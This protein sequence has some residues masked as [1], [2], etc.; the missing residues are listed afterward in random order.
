MNTLQTT[1]FNL[2]DAALHQKT[3]AKISVPQ[4]TKRAGSSPD[5]QTTNTQDADWD[6]I[7]KE[8]E[9]QAVIGIPLEY[10]I[11]NTD[12]PQ[13]QKDH[14]TNI[15]YSQVAQWTKIMEAQNDLIQLLHKNNIKLA[16]I[17]GITAA[18]NY[19][20]PDY[21]SMG[22]VDFFVEGEDF[23]KTYQIM[24][25]NGY[26]LAGDESIAQM[27]V[28]K[29]KY[30]HIELMKN[31]VT[32]ELHRRMSD[33]VQGKETDAKI[34][35]LIQE[36]MNHIQ[37]GQ[38]GEYEFPM[39]EEKLNGLIILRHI[40]QHLSENKGVGLRHVIDWMQFVEKHVDDRA[41]QETYAKYLDAVNL[42]DAAI[43][44]ARMGQ[45]YLGL[46][47]SIAWCKG[48]TP[49]TTL[50][51]AAEQEQNEIA[52]LATAWMEQILA[53]GNFGAKQTAADE[54]TGVLYKNKNFFTIIG[55]LQRL[56]MEHWEAA[57]KHRA[58]KPLAWAYQAG[59][60]AKKGLGRKN[61]IK[62]LK[63]DMDK[64]NYKKEL[65]KGLKIN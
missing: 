35:A 18:M 60:Y 15:V 14:W 12:A 4:D 50:R 21:R 5:A 49:A 45:M 29:E 11:N 26:S 57:R 32:F 46:D 28:E 54:G 22:D 34:E 53:S 56:G 64:S 39:F 41:W 16:I 58:L 62:S 3:D 37:T 30:H 44:F 61:P 20:K 36:G 42:K 43:V 27:H 23:E 13:D 59:R 31:G 63:Q 40:I 25:Q 1:I 48:T 38:V 2:I 65:L 33:T 52:K 17:K 9:N 8:L 55:S 47:K 10:M 7:L 51:E 19:P 6:A 24:T